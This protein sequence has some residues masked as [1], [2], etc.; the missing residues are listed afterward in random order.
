[1]YS[2]I[3]ISEVGPAEYPLIAVLRDTIFAEFHHRY[4]AALEEQ[5]KGR[6]DVLALI[7]H[8]EGNPVGYKIGYHDKPGLYYSWSGGVLKDYRGQGV[9]RRMQEW[10]HAWLRAR[11]YRMVHFTSF[12]KFR[13]MLRFGVETG[14]IPTGIDLSPEGELS[15]RLRKDL[16]Q[17]DPPCRA[18]HPPAQVHVESVGAT[19]HGLIAQ[20]A[21]ETLRPTTEAEI[22]TEMSNRGPLAM[23]AFVENTPVGFAI[24]HHRDARGELF[25]SSLVGVLPQFQDRGVAT[26]LVRRQMAAAGEARCRAF[27]ILTPHNNIPLIRLC[28]NLGLNIAGMHHDE[29]R[30]IEL[31]IFE[32]SL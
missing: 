27:Q 31:L 4:A 3:D 12:N 32:Q 21:S 16:T 9:A 2:Q 1:M 10:Q 14:F 29:R 25:Q 22:D 17:P 5:V 19:Y 8:L 20:L 18:K 11:G 15:I 7:A 24:G 23:V 26:E 6:Q 13:P 30:A 28:L